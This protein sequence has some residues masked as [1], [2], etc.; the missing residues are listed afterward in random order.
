MDLRQLAAL[1]AVAD[2][3]SFSA[4]ARA[5]HTVQSNVSTHVAHLE[6]ELGTILVDRS[7]G[8]LT[9]T[10]ELVAAR[11]RRVQAELEALTA[12]VA[13][14]T[15]QISG[16]V[17]FGVIGTIARWLVPGLLAAVSESHPRIQVVVVDAS[18]TSLVPQLV[19]GRLD[20]A[21]LNLP[22]RDPELDVEPLFVEDRVLVVPAGHP[23]ADVEELTIAELAE[24]PLVLEPPGTGYRDD[25]DADAARAGVAFTP[26]AEVDGMRLVASLAF[27]GYGPAV[28][29]ATAAPDPQ[30]GSW[31]LVAINGLTPRSV[32][33]ATRR[34]SLLSAPARAVHDLLR[35]VVTA[36]GA[37]HP[38]LHLVSGARAADE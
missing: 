2:H 35:R 30:P 1:G 20:L 28:L 22:L 24:H 31:Q 25:L 29:P 17:R 32:G 34:R 3:G 4:A 12:D 37:R 5:L 6:R 7:T 21:V 11:A 14:V 36:E 9:D 18:T 33:V 15:D 27:E 10:G 19:Q 13:S 8:R 38:G 26:L 16:A 23:L